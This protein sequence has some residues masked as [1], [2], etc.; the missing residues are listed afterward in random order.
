M[1]NARLYEIM[2]EKDVYKRQAWDAGEDDP[3]PPDGTGPPGYYRGPE[4]WQ[5]CYDCHGPRPA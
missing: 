3:A 2:K 5:H 4:K 1:G